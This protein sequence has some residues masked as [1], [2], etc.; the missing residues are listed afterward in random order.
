M[1]ISRMNIN[2]M[3]GKIYSHICFERDV[4]MSV[5]LKYGVFG[6]MA[7]RVLK[8]LMLAFS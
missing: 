8:S 2:S 7:H 6:K 1:L 5:R 4:D 3:I